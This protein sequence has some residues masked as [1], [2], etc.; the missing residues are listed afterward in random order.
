MS[1]TP[2]FTG[3]ALQGIEDRI[4]LLYGIAGNAGVEFTPNVSLN[5]DAGSLTDPGTN[6]FRGRRWFFTSAEDTALASVHQNLMF[7]SPVIIE[8]V[9]WNMRAAGG[10][11]AIRLAPVLPGGAIVPSNDR[12]LFWRETYDA[13]FINQN[14]PMFFS[15]FVAGT[16]GT[17]LYCRGVASPTLGHQT[18]D[19]N[20]FLPGK[21]ANDGSPDPYTYGIDMT[22]EGSHAGGFTW[23]A[24]GR[25]F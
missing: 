3:S 23:G 8:K 12:T 24:M 1:F 2:K 13:D 17:P 18:F 21:V 5:V 9:W 16:G 14:P 7:C 11:N 20:V 4:R 6:V 22:C 10:S 25:M 15:A 19:L